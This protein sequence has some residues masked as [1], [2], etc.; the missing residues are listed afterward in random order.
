M[1]L[2]PAKPF[3]LG[4]GAGTPV[5]REVQGGVTGLLLDGRGRPLQLPAD[6]ET[7]VTTLARWFRAVDLYPQ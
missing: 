1:T 6:Q 5:R 4:A 2:Q 7:R 3:N